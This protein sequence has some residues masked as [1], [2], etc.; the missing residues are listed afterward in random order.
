[1][2]KHPVGFAN[3]SNCIYNYTEELNDESINSA[4][5]WYE[6]QGLKP[7]EKNKFNAKRTEWTNKAQFGKSLLG[8][9]R[10]KKNDIYNCF[11]EQ[12]GSVT[13]SLKSILWASA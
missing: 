10:E 4:I 13:S 6:I 12:N 3:K 2:N 7:L 9:C 8:Q 5:N 11:A 1:M